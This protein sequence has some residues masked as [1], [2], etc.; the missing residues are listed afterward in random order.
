MLHNSDKEALERLD[1]A[2]SGYLTPDELE[3]VKSYLERWK[4]WIVDIEKMHVL[5]E[6]NKRIT[7]M[8]QSKRSK[9]SKRIVVSDPA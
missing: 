6:L 1:A 2:L 9:R 3:E 5:E 7:T 8:K 4:R